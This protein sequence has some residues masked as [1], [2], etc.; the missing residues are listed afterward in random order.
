MKLLLITLIMLMLAIL[1]IMH[2]IRCTRVPSTNKQNTD[3]H[4]NTICSL[5]HE[6][7]LEYKQDKQTA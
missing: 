7:N 3:I 2:T 5:P 1:R 6:N 4:T